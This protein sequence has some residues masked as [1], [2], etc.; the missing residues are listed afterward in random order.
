MKTILLVD[1]DIRI[2]ES[3]EEILNTFGYRVISRP[4]AESALSLLREGIGI[5]L[6]ITDYRMPGMNGV[7][8][9]MVLRQ[10]LP[11]VPVI[12]LTGYASVEVYLKSVSLGAFEYINKPVKMKVLNRIVKSA[13]KRSAAGNAV[14]LS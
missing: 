13:L 5:D 12:I 2:L 9:I 4:D 10:I 3:L 11:S 8:F 1:D 14:L 6:V 7:E